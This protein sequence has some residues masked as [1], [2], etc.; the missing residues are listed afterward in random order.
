MQQRIVGMN[1][2]RPPLVTRAGAI[3]LAITLAVGVYA[4]GYNNGLTAG[5]SAGASGAIDLSRFNEVLDLVEQRHVGDETEQQLIDGA[6]RGLVES[7]NDPYSQYLTSEEMEVMLGDLSGSF[8]GIGAVIES[9]SPTGDSCTTIGPDCYL[10]VV[11]PID[12]SPAKAAGIVSGDRVTAVD[13]VSVDGETLDSSVRR[14]RG[15]KGTTVVITVVRG[16]DAPKD[17]S[18]VRDV[19]VVPAVEPKQLSTAAGDPVGYIRLAEFSEV[20]SAQFRTAL[21]TVIDAGTTRIIL[22]LRDNPGGYLSAAL[23]IASEFIGDGVVYME[24]T[25]NGK[26]TE[27]RASGGGLATDPS[28]KL[29]VLINKGSASAS[30]ILASALQDRGRAELVGETT[31]GKGVVQTF[32]DLSDGSGLKLTI[33]KW[34][35]PNG[36]WVHKVGIAP[37]YPVAPASTQG[38]DDLVLTKALDLLK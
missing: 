38:A 19:I 14:V 2:K 33:A 10:L 1:N 13:G 37:D 5:T 16:E 27:T 9:R 18:I 22:D 12:G 7:L 6:I 23:A 31:F 26:R 30:E 28:I 4:L 21:Q 15:A 24:E 3:L 20:A 8:E 25:S 34:L 32:I 17:I 35:T 36:T 29:V 11:S